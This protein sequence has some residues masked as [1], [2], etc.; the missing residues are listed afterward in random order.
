[1]SN[2]AVHWA[3]GAATTVGTAHTA[4]TARYFQEIERISGLCGTRMIALLFLQAH[5]LYERLSI[6]LPGSGVQVMM[7]R[8]GTY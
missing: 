5:V 6:F 8:H 7:R 1:M 4:K 3:A 2:V